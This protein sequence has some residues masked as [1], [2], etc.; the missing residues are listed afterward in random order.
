[1]IETGVYDVVLMDC[2]MP[3][4]DGYEA[5]RRLRAAQKSWSGIR[6][7][8]VTA[9]ATTADRQHCFDAGMDD[10]V[11]KPLRMGDVE[12][13]LARCV[14]SKTPSPVQANG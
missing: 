11:A 13:V 12:S 1:M 2:H 5:T 4:V 10:F 8:A 7:I 6:V 3:V 9:N 14:Q